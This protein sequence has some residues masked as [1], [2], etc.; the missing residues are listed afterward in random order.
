MISEN[1]V[2]AITEYILW[3]YGRRSE[4]T[5]KPLNPNLTKEH[6]REWNRLCRNARAQDNILTDADRELM[7]QHFNDPYAGRGLWVGMYPTGY[8][9]Y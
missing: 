9:F 5:Q 7:S 6:Q 3:Q 1:H 4:Y 2:R 8:N